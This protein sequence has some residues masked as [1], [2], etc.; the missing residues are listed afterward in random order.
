MEQDYTA[1]IKALLG[2]LAAKIPRTLI[3]FEK[4]EY[5]N[6]EIVDRLEVDDMILLRSYFNSL[7]HYMRK[8]EASDIDVGGYGTRGMIWFRVHGKKKPVPG[9]GGFDTDE[10][11]IL[12]Q[13]LLMKSQR[14]HIIKHKNLD[15]SYVFKNSEGETF[16]N[17]ADAYID[18]DSIALNMRAINTQI[19][20]YNSYDF[21]E[22]VSR[23]FS[24]EHTKEGLILITGITGSGKSTTLD[25][26]VDMNNQTVEGHIVIIASPIEFVHTSK[27]CIVRHREVGRDTESFKQGTVE[28]L[29]QDPDIIVIGEMRDPDTIMR[30]L[31]AADSGHKVISTLHTSSAVESIDRIIG[32]VS[33]NDQDRVRNRLADVLKCVISQK[34]IPGI[35]G[36]R[37][38]AKEVMVMTPPIR[39]TIKNENTSEIYQL[40]NEGQKYGMFTV[41]QDLKL[42]YEK[43]QITLENAFNYANNKRRIQQLIHS[44]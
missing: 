6:N 16:R 25:S 33:A 40:I 34:L 39:S 41:E 5:I 14:E 42:L 43:R 37:V 10:L 28:A 44:K 29:R 11:D 21:H 23:I 2:N 31:E 22:E 4:L 30:A 12:I 35:G 15:F 1:R 8:V 9:L 27:K 36:K 3:S 26:I 17:R 18:L 7:L 20:P 19:R 24:L 13:T 32:E 38:L